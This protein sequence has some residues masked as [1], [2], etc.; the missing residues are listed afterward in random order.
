MAAG[1]LSEAQEANALFHRFQAEVSRIVRGEPAPEATSNVKPTQR[2]L[3]NFRTLGF[4]GSTRLTS[5]RGV[6]GR[7]NVKRSTLLGS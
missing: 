1:F 2:G 7:A 5:G 4:S 6:L 3:G